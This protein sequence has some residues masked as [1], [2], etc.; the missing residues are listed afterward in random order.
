M[1]A[2]AGRGEEG[3]ETEVTEVTDLLERVD[4]KDLEAEDVDVGDVRP[5][6]AAVRARLDLDGRLRERAV[7]ALDEPEEEV[8]IELLD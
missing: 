2:R 1:E 3:H 6:P 8:G 5:T 7:D 4:C